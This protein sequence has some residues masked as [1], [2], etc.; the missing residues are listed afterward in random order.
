VTAAR[1]T[2]R[3]GGEAA[4]LFYRKDRAAQVNWLAPDLETRHPPDA[5]FR[6]GRWERR[7]ALPVK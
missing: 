5:V 3:N 2:L 4:L 7:G 6:D 1:G